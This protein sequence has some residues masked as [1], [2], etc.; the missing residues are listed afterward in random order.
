MNKYNFS[1]LVLF[2]E[3]QKVQHSINYPL[4]DIRYEW[5]LDPIIK[6]RV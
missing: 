5:T 3:T 2:P 4:A 6:G 1:L